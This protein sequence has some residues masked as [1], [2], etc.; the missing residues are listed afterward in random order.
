MCVTKGGYSASKNEKETTKD[1]NCRICFLQDR[2]LHIESKVSLK[3]YAT[4]TSSRVAFSTFLTLNDNS[5][6]FCLYYSI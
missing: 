2:A 4:G 5:T 3:C 1:G 6:T